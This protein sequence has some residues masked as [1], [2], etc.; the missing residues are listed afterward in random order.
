MSGPTRWGV[1]GAGEISHDWCVALATLPKDEH[2]VVAIAARDVGRAE[3]FAE[4]HKI[5]KVHKTYEDLIKDV[6]V[7]K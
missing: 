1:L 5:T 7:G 2:Q 6:N 4:M 3:K